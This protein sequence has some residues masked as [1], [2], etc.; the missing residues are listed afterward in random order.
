VLA[1]ALAKHLDERYATVAQFQTEL[2]AA[3]AGR[4]DSAVAERANA[5]HRGAPATAT[6]VG[7]STVSGAADTVVAST[8]T[9]DTLSHG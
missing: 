9:D 4:Q 2:S 8:S 6:A 5:L 3:L 7:D 1:I